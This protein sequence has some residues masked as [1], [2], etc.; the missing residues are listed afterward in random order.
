MTCTCM[1]CICTCMTCIC[2]I[3]FTH[4]DYIHKHTQCSAHTGWHWS[5]IT[6]IQHELTTNEMN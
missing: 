1:T 6:T 3:A 2:T 4:I 5:G